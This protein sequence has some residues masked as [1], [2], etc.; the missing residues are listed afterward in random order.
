MWHLF[1]CDILTAKSDLELKSLMIV[2]LGRGNRKMYN[3]A[4]EYR[5]NIKLNVLKSLIR[6]NHNRLNRFTHSLF[7]GREVLKRGSTCRYY[8]CFDV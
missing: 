3:I 5:K 7:I 4:G 8:I 6:N 1:Y 2:Y